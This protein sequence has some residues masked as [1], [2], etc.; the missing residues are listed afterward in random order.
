MYCRQCQLKGGDGETSEGSIQQK[1][2]NV[3]QKHEMRRGGD[4]TQTCVKVCCN[5]MAV[6]YGIQVSG[7]TGLKKVSVPRQGPS[8]KT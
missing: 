6:I 4:S 5:D 3:L 1:M 8:S 2:I 7:P